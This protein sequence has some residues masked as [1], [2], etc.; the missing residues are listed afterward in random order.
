MLG[1]GELKLI[2]CLE[3]DQYWVQVKTETKF[4]LNTAFPS[5]YGKR[6]AHLIWEGRLVLAILD[7]AG[8]KLGG[9]IFRLFPSEQGTN[10]PIYLESTLADY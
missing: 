1:F 5:I 3:P 8:E 10:E 7:T 2:Y 4:F 9:G 6:S